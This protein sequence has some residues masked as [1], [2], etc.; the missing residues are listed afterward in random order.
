MLEARKGVSIC[1][2]MKR[3]TP[4]ASYILPTIARLSGWLM[5]HLLPRSSVGSHC[6]VSGSPDLPTCASAASA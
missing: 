5:V 1:E 4:L 2:P 6:A 3:G